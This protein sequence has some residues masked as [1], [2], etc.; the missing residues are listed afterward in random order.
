M[1]ESASEIMAKILKDLDFKAENRCINI[2]N[3]LGNYQDYIMNQAIENEDS[4]L[5]EEKQ[6]LIDIPMRGRILC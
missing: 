6:K 2:N 3:I 5:R 4:I 1:E